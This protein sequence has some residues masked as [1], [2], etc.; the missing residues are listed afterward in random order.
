MR[1]LALSLLR[2]RIKNEER[3][4]T[5]FVWQKKARILRPIVPCGIGTMHYRSFRLLLP[6]RSPEQGPSCDIGAAETRGIVG[7]EFTI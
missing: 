6:L 3:I 7:R 5:A 2:A 1:H 4:V